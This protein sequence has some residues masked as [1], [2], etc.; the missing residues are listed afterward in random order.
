MPIQGVE[1]W[2]KYLLFLLTIPTVTIGKINTVNSIFVFKLFLN[3]NAKHSH[4][5][6][7]ISFN[8]TNLK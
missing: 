6:T 8:Y 4:Y 3:V 5:N 7:Y 2:Q 1:A